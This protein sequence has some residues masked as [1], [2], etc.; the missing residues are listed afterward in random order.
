MQALEACL[1]SAD[2][3]VQPTGKEPGSDSSF[4]LGVKFSQRHTN[5]HKTPQK[6]DRLSII[7]FAVEK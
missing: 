2:R 6:Q 3:M 7:F 5:A 1:A 4:C